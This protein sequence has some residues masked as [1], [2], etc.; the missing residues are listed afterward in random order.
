[1]E[2]RTIAKYFKFLIEKGLITEDEDFYYLA[3]LPPDEANL[4]EYNTL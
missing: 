1:M 4:I 3:V 2:R